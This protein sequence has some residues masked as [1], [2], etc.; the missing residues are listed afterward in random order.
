MDLTASPMRGFPKVQHAQWSHTAVPCRGPAYCVGALSPRKDDV[1]HGRVIARRL[2]AACAALV[3]VVGFASPAA[4]VADDPRASVA[5]AQWVLKAA[6]TVHAQEA[7]TAAAQTSIDGGTRL[8]PAAV[9]VGF[10][11]EQLGK[12]Y[13]WG[14]TG[15]DTFDCS[16]LTF[17]AWERGGVT[18]E[19]H[20]SNQWNNGKPI[21]PAKA[22]GGDLVFFG[23]DPNEPNSINHVALAIGDGMVV[24]APHPGA[25]VRIASMWRSSLVGVVRISPPPPTGRATLTAG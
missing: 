24:E 23:P 20:S 22:R 17:R 4:A 14:A 8:D 10:A 2:L 6:A 5:H 21:D 15:P 13:V 16:G 1:T 9:V 19:R 11:L 7:A 3:A 12:P 18:L 25:T